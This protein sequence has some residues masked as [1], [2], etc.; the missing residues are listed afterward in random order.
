MSRRSTTRRSTSPR[1]SSACSRS[2]CSGRAGWSARNSWS[3]G[4]A[5]WGEE[6]SNNAIEVYVHRLR[7]KIEVGGVRIVTVRGLGYCLERF[8]DTQ[9]RGGDGRRRL[10]GR[11]AGRRRYAHRRASARSTLL[12]S[13]RAARTSRAPPPPPATT[14][15]YKNPLRAFPRA[16][17]AVRRDPRLDAGAA[18]AAV[19]D[20]RDAHLPR[21]PVDRQRP[22]RPHPAAKPWPCSAI[23]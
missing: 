10:I 15:G 8:T 14:D 18:A 5:S 3:T 7:K 6:V 23:T 22:V 17:L 13:S 9:R 20:E 12:R 11:H 16:E 19:A 1:A 4:C 2:C 21:R